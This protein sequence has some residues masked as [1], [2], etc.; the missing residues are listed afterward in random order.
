M[1]FLFIL[2]VYNLLYELAVFFFM[3]IPFLVATVPSLNASSTFGKHF[4]TCTGNGNWMTNIKAHDRF[5]VCYW[6][7]FR[8]LNEIWFNGANMAEELLPT[9]AQPFA[10]LGLYSWAICRI[11]RNLLIIL[12]S[13]MLRL[14]RESKYRKKTSDKGNEDNLNALNTDSLAA[15]R[16]N[17]HF[18]VDV[19]HSCLC[20]CVSNIQ[21]TCGSIRLWFGVVQKEV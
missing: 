7:G 15:V 13:F 2:L 8:T 11:G 5:P 10:A 4:L 19:T 14:Y 21:Y 12:S 16:I 20:L 17:L 18:L 6:V 1:T 9:S 3:G